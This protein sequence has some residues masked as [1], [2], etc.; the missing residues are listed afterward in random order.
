MRYRGLHGLADAAYLSRFLFS[1]LRCVAL[2][3]V[4]SSVRVVSYIVLVAPGE[5]EGAYTAKSK[6]ASLNTA[7]AI[8]HFR[9]SLFCW[10][11]EYEVLRTTCP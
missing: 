10:S 2:Y 5:R 3:C 9:P 8:M 4:P 6:A 7:P 1:A 11:E